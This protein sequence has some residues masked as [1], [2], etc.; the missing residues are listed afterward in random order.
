MESD[1]VHVVAFITISGAIFK[2]LHVIHQIESPP[3]T[4]KRRWDYMC[5][6]LF[7]TAVIFSVLADINQSTPSHKSEQKKSTRSIESRR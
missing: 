7:A 3:P 4:G 2:A 1:L 6:S 5:A